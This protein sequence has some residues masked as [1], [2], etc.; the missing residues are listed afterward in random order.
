MSLNI[1]S[2]SGSGGLVKQ[3]KGNLA[4]SSEE[5][6][7]DRYARMAAIAYGE[8]LP[9]RA[10]NEG[11]F[12]TCMEILEPQMIEIYDNFPDIDADMLIATGYLYAPH[13][14]DGYSIAVE[15]SFDDTV[16]PLIDEYEEIEDVMEAVD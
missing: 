4:N 15:E 2:L 1:G 7:R 3:F 8:D 11:Q 6:V 12:A 9:S 5:L 14:M 16:Q 10:V 13:G